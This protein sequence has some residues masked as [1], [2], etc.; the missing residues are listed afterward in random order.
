VPLAAKVD[1]LRRAASY[2]HAVGRVEAI[3]THLSWVFLTDTEAYK[4]KKPVLSDFIDLRSMERRRRNAEQE[5]RLNR[6]LAP[7]VYVGVVALTLGSD[8]GLQVGVAGQPVDWL[9]HMRRLPSECMLDIAIRDGTVDRA[10]L[11][12]A[13]ELLAR[14]YRDNTVPDVTPEGFRDHVRRAVATNHDLLMQWLDEPDRGRAAATH[15][16]QVGLVDGDPA[17]FDRRVAAGRI[18]EGHGD[19]RPEHVCL[20]REP[21]VIDCLEF[22]RAHRITDPVDELTFLGMECARLDAPE[23]GPLVFD[24]Y[25]DIARDDP[26]ARLV[27][28]YRCYRAS[29]RA[30][31]AAWHLQDPEVGDTKKWTDRVQ[32]YL[33]IAEEAAADL[34]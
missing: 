16:A 19:L 10:R 28:F 3:E 13:A 32:L 33:G 31:L 6:R 11:G 22:D 9:V 24:T 4:L 20:V 25:R 8:G 21:V 27:A 1:F 15:R 5:V 14:F 12:K 18:V 17:L 7:W 30:R 34:S 26:P 2:P 23:L 29:L